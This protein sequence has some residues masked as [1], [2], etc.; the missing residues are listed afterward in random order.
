MHTSVHTFLP[1]PYYGRACP[2]CRSRRSHR[3]Q[4]AALGL[5]FNPEILRR[6]IAARLGG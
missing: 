5:V 4:R 2:A 3:R 6:R 1:V